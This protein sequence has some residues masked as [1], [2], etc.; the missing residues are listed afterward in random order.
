M[1]G[2]RLLSFTVVRSI[3]IEWGLYWVALPL[4]A[5]RIPLAHAANGSKGGSLTVQLWVA[6]FLVREE[7][8]NRKECEER[9]DELYEYSVRRTL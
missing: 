4:G 3:C 7:R 8:L 9:S 5:G 1:I 2:K 6:S